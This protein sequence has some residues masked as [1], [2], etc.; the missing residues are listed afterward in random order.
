MGTAYLTDPVLRLIDPEEMPNSFLVLS[1]E[2]Q[3]WR[4]RLY[5]II[6]WGVHH[7]PYAWIHALQPGP[8]T[9]TEYRAGVEAYPDELHLAKMRGYAA[10]IAVETGEG[11]ERA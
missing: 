10:E 3:H 2:E 7:K 1:D 4:G 9:T 5:L 6:L 11:L 8:P